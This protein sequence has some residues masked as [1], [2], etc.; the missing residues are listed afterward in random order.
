MKMKLFLT[1]SCLGLLTGCCYQNGQW[2]YQYNKTG[3]CN[4][5]CANNCD[6]DVYPNPANHACFNNVGGY[7]YSDCYTPN[8][9]SGDDDQ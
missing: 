6:Q 7:C 8:C 2:V 4:Y 5:Q 3:Y 9:S 1:L